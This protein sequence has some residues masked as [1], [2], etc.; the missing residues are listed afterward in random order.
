MADFVFNI[1][2]GRVVEL[3][4]RVDIADPAAAE[5]VIAILATT[6]LESE[7]FRHVYAGG[8]WHDK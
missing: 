4:N 5:L 6:G 1:S 7:G 2:L 8:G 3:Y